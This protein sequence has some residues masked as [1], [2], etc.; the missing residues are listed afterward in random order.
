MMQSG[1]AGLGRLGWKR[2]AGVVLAGA[3]SL[4]CA[5][6]LGSAGNRR[7][8]TV[9][10][11]VSRGGAS[12][13]S[14]TGGSAAFALGSANSALDIQSADV[15]FSEVTFEGAGVDGNDNEDS[16]T[17]SDSDHAGNA[18]FRSGP[19]T[20]ALPLSGGVITPLT[21]Q[22][23]LGTY[24]R[25]E[26]D[27]EFVRVRGTYNGQQFDVTVPVNA[28]LELRLEPPLAVT[29]SSDPVNVSVAIQVADWFRDRNGNVI[30]PRQL[31]T[32]A[33]LRSEFRSRVRASFKAFEDQDRDADEEDSDSDSD[34]D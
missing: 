31:Q 12:L 26:M 19:V 15:V 13:V 34:S 5:D 10:F 17:D 28:E 9:S 29:A 18:R 3:S 33:T 4:A 20:V 14:A 32:N 25:L 8:A 1:Q 16:D 30:D 6:F 7:D 2:V 27:A 23:P 11:S 24:S 22:L 21:G